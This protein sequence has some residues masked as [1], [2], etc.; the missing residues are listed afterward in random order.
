MKASIIIAYHNEGE[1]FLRRAVSQVRN[2]CGSNDIEIIV[3][4]DHSSVTP[5]IPGVVM[6]RNPIQM[7]VGAAFDAGVNAATSQ[8][9]ILMGCDIRIAQ[10][11]WLDKMISA[12]DYSHNS[13][14]CTRCIPVN[15]NYGYNDD[16]TI[17]HDRLN[18]RDGIGATL[19]LKHTKKCPGTI[20]TILTAQWI[21]SDGK[22]TGLVD[23]PVILGAFYAVKKAWYEYIDGF[24][25]HKIWGTLEPLISIKSYK[26]GGDCMCHRDVTVGHIFMKSSIHRIPPEIIYYNKIWAATTL[27]NP[28]LRDELMAW[29]PNNINVKNGKKMIDRELVAAKH[30]EYQGLSVYS[31][32]EL[33]GRMKVKY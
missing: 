9:I 12:I 26:F 29:L 28:P 16:A 17:C 24:N 10:A 6:I 20:N 2:T 30:Y 22:E 18:N 19:L 4:D 31:D 5:S 33:L 15:N 3:V 32:A 8:N 13:L 21:A 1:A 23:V 11:G 7:G 25:G 14:V 27:F